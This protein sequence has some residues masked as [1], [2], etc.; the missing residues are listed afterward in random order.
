MAQGWCNE[1]LKILKRES[2]VAPF[3]FSLSFF[4]SVLAT[5]SHSPQP[6]FFVF[7][8]KASRAGIGRNNLDAHSFQ[9]SKSRGEGIRVRAWLLFNSWLGFRKQFKPS[10]TW[11]CLSI[12]PE[13]PLSPQR[14]QTLRSRSV[15]ALLPESCLLLHKG[16]VWPGSFLWISDSTT[17]GKIIP[18]HNIM[19][20]LT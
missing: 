17:G 7:E 8:E 4:S 2:K 19:F 11:K 15:F 14:I 1:T 13:I 12:T 5:K 6:A 10:Q 9:C 20:W 3:S 18:A 16:E